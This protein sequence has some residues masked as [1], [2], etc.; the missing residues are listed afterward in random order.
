MPPISDHTSV[1]PN[2]GN[3]D[4]EY[5]R[6][7]RDTALR[8]IE[9]LE[10]ARDAVSDSQLSD[11]RLFIQ[12]FCGLV[13]LLGSA[14][15]EIDKNNVD[16]FWD[17]GQAVVSLRLATVGTAAGWGYFSPSEANGLIKEFNP[18]RI[19]SPAPA[20]EATVPGE[21]WPR[22]SS[23]YKKLLDAIEYTFTS[24]D[25]EKTIT[26]LWDKLKTVYT[27][28]GDIPMPDE[29]AIA[30]LL[31]ICLKAQGKPKGT[32]PNHEEI[33]EEIKRV[34][35]Y[36]NCNGNN[37]P[38]GKTKR[39]DY[40]SCIPLLPASTTVIASNGL[41]IIETSAE[42]WF[43][44]SAL[45][46]NRAKARA[47]R[48]GL[49]PRECRENLKR[50]TENIHS[51][52]EDFKNGSNSRRGTSRKSFLRKWYLAQSEEASEIIKVPG[53][54]LT[55][56]PTGDFKHARFLCAC[57]FQP[58]MPFNGAPKPN[59]TENVQNLYPAESCSEVLCY[60]TFK[61]RLEEPTESGLTHAMSG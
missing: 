7:V 45:S 39:K 25:K 32:Y 42:K 57:R 15:T 37:K 16:A 14:L 2:T 46:E 11:T 33:C 20:G 21:R 35:Q 49:C 6:E 40:K 18:E 8:G 51:Q 61:L 44:L 38:G 19:A 4:R 9:Y 54:F 10:L 50:Q 31:N 28:N 22:S 12:Y 43:Y 13:T 47:R 34:F 60:Y 56:K 59:D 53:L 24:Y 48:I 52:L 23:V 27:V 29:S 17:A 58:E 55:F 36:F 3:N 41:L 5:L 26:R 30:L 1:S